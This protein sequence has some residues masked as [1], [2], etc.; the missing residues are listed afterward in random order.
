MTK[1][2]LKTRGSSLTILPYSMIINC[3]ASYVLPIIF[4]ISYF[5]AYTANYRIF[6][7]FRH[8][9]IKGSNMDF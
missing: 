4:I 5:Y 3:N 6:H 9:G 1:V 8:R 7:F 2:V